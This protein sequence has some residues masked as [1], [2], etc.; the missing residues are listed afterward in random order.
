ME[1]FWKWLLHANA[2]R[3]LASSVLVLVLVMAY[4]TWR[5]FSP[6]KTPGLPSGNMSQKEERHSLGFQVALGDQPAEIVNPFLPKGWQPP[7]P[8]VEVAVETGTADPAV[9]PT[10][11]GVV[12]RPVIRRPIV[13]A[14]RTR[15]AV[16]GE[17]RPTRTVVVQPG[18]A[19]GPETVTLVYKGVFQGTDG[20]A[21]ALIED[22][23]Q[24][25]S[26]FYKT[27]RDVLGLKVGDITT[28]EV[29]I[30]DLKGK[31]VPVKLREPMA[32]ELPPPR[33]D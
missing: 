33:A 30:T 7:R 29:T 19:A 13:R 25:R 24:Q 18:A 16:A 14:T 31:V 1:T 22:S 9:R 4:W 27:G 21:M 28:T 26:R 20:K 11:P 8:P 10:R 32:F 15:P 3:V 23:R 2:K 5:E 6:P 17:R 12:A